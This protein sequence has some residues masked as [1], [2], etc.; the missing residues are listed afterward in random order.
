MY[1]VIANYG[2]LIYSG[3]GLDAYGLQKAL[4]WAGIPSEL[5]P[6]YANKI[7]LYYTVLSNKI[8]EHHK[9]EMERNKSRIK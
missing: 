6:D 5:H 9:R 8:H 1:G 7:I 2:N 3:E 4:E